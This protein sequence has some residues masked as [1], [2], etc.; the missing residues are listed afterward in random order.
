MPCI[1]AMQGCLCKCW[2]RDGLSLV[3]MVRYL[4]N[5]GHFVFPLCGFSLSLFCNY[6]GHW[7]GLVQQFTLGGVAKHVCKQDEG[8]GV[9]N[10]SA[11]NT[12][13]TPRQH[14]TPHTC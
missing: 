3:W 11:G 7:M 14:L 4:T 10:T 13:A 8:W 6:V 12:S 1:P 9:D 2:T 5:V